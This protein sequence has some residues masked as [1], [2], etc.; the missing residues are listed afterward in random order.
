MTRKLFGRLCLTAIMYLMYSAATSPLFSQDTLKT[1]D[2]TDLRNFYREEMLLESFD[3]E[4]E[5]PAVLDN[6][7]NLRR[8]PLDLNMITYE[9]LDLIPFVSS[10][11]ARKIIDYRNEIGKFK[12]KRELLK[13]EGMS[14]ELYDMI[15]IYIIVRRSKTDVIIDETGIRYNTSEI[16]FFDKLNTRVRS[17]FL[18]DL[19]TKA[20]YISQKYEGTKP[21]LYTSV[22]SKFG[23]S[24][25]TINSDK[26]LEINLTLEKD[27]GEKYINDF[28][29]GYIEG[30]GFGILKKFIAGDYSLNFGQGLTLSNSSYFSKGIDAV[31]PLKRKGKGIDGYSSVNESQFFRGASVSLEQNNFY[32][33]LF[34]SYNYLDAAVDEFSEE[35][36]TIYI[37]GYHRTSSEINRKNS[38]KENLFGGRFSYTKGLLR[39]GITYWSGK[40]S[41]SVIKDTVRELYDFSGDKASSLGGDYDVLYKN[42]N[43]FGEWTYSNSGAVASI[44]SVSF[45]FPGLVQLVMSYRNYPY[46]FISVHSSGFGERGGETRNERGFYTG[47]TLKPLKGLVLNAYFDQFKIPYRTYLNPLPVSGNDLLFNADWRAQKGFVINLKIKSETKEDLQTI[48]NLNLQDI[49]ITDRRSQFNARLGFIYQ[50]TD[51]LRFRSR[52]EF[53]NVKY[54]MSGASSKGRLFYSDMRL[55]PFRGIIF[56]MRIIY[57][58]TE[59]YDSRIYEYENDIK[60]IMTNIALYGKGRRWYAVM[61]YK[62]FPLFEISAKYSETYT[63]G[64]KTIGSGNDMIEGDIVN[65]LNV[66]VEINF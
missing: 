34:Y 44:N 28:T 23:K 8:N 4:A 47:L 63:D 18:Q 36:S 38:L 60:G 58:D 5:E 54:D 27:P 57:F 1:G 19:Q 24:G 25:K 45:S 49:K 62:P 2:T 31:S 12:S 53:V 3:P 10:V 11:I 17:R 26:Y 64:V 20:G 35:A 40:Y 52:F 61:R 9:E 46:D 59:N 6:L 42:M 16:T 55:M 29:S 66:G 14:I 22:N 41:R 33:D 7:E 65:R 50:L 39:T 37:D 43:A 15:K 30:G 32:L 13:I 51:A 48:Q 21:K 56:D